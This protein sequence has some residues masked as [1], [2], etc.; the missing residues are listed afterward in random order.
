MSKVGLFGAAIKSL[1]AYSA[2]QSSR[3]SNSNYYLNHEHP[4][5]SG[6]GHAAAIKRQAKKRKNLK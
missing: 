6:K 1:I 3:F 5:A 4:T 2:W